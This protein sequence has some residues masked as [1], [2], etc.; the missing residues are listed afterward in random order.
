M[1]SH[2]EIEM[3]AYELWEERGR[4][5]GEPETDWFAAEKG[6]ADEQNPLSKVAREVGGALGNIVSALT[7][8]KP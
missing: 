8:L 7:S 4:P 5:I 6:I 1:I 3:R 2:E